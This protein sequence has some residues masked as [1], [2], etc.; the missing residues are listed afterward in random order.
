[1]QLKPVYKKLAAAFAGV[2]S[3]AVAAMD[4]TA[5]DV[6]EGY[7]VSGYP[8]IFFKKAGAKAEPYDGG[9]DLDTMVTFIKANAAVKITGE[10]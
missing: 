6:P 4:A 9:R 10:L 8:T 5:N 2:P 1:M 3:V 7:E